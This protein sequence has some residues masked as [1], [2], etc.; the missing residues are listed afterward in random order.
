MRKTVFNVML[1]GI[2]VLGLTA[3][4]GTAGATT[5]A[6]TSEVA[7]QTAEEN[8]Q[9]SQT[10]ESQTQTASAEESGMETQDNADSSEQTAEGGKR[11]LIAYFSWSGNTEA[12]AELIQEQTGGELFEITPAVPYTDDYDALLDQAQAEQK[13]NARPELAGQVENWDDYEVVF[14]GYPNW[15]G[16]T[17][18]T[19]LTFLESHDFNG[20]TLIPFCTHGSGGFGRSLSS[21]EQSAQGAEILE[22]FEISGGNA[23]G[24]GTQVEEWL[25]SIGMGQ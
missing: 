8:T 13:E 9:G 14:V 1:A 17:P 12:L 21:V 4:S 25:A 22:G 10:Q 6:Q 16:D 19:V 18:M 23:A 7:M 3:C 24:A 20:K 11:P 15:W 2:L 5:A